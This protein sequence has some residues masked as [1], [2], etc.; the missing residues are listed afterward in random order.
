M[1]A[2]DPL[3]K[4]FDAYRLRKLI[5]ASDIT[6]KLFSITMRFLGFTLGREPIIADLTDENAAK[7]AVWIIEHRRIKPISVNTY[8]G[9]FLALWGFAHRQG[10]LRKYPDFEGL[11]ESEVIPTAWSEC[12]L[13]RLFATILTLR[14]W[15]GT[16]RAR[17]WWL[18]YGLIAWDSGERPSAIL[19]IRRTDVN[20]SAGWL[21]TR[22]ATRKGKTRDKINWLHSDTITTI[23]RIWLPERELLLPFPHHYVTFLNHY[24][25]ILRAAGLPCDRCHMPYCLRKSHGTHL[26]NAGGD[27]VAS[28]DHSDAR[29]YKKH[30]RDVRLIRG[31]K[32]CDLLFR[33][34]DDGTEPAA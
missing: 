8:L 29:I 21:I 11:R 22:A 4:L 9:K 32:P 28:L 10:I 24:R 2:T 19:G 34:L 23:R 1:K 20:L 31:I 15:E 16:L 12:E 26:E 30:Y 7:L 6:L 13:R 18:A 14:G 27:P 25:K 5:G 33:P 3:R 17:D